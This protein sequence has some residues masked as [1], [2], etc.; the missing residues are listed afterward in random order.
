MDKSFDLIEFVEDRP[1]HD[2]RYSL[3]SSKIRTELNWSHKVSF[4]NGLKNTIQW[5]QSNQEWW[6]N[7]EESTFNATP[8]KN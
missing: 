7:V 4:E 3:D 2:F 5:Y 8:W 1:G 6:K